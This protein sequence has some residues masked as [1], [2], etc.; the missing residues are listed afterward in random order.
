MA[1]NKTTGEPRTYAAGIPVYCTY[2]EIVPIAQLKPNPM[3]PNKH[4][5]EQIEALGGIIR[6]SGWRNNITVSTR[7]GLI[8]KGHGRLMAAQLEELKEAP[9]EYQ[10]YA[11][12]AEELA[13]LTADNRLAELAEIDNSKLAEVFAHIDT[14]EI[15]FEQSGYSEEE[16]EKLTTALSEAIH[17]DLED[18]DVV[19][20]PP[21]EPVTKYGDIWILGG[22]HRVMCGS[23]TNPED[24][25]KLLNGE[26]PQILLTDPPYC[27]GGSKESDKSTGSIGT[28]RKNGELPMIAND[29]LSTRGYQNLIAAALA[30]IPCVYAYIFTD[31]RMWVYLFDLS[32]NAGF[33]VMGVGWRSQHELCLF[34]TRAKTHFDGHKGYGNVLEISRSGMEI[35]PG[36]V[37]VIVRRYIRM[38]NSRNVKCIRGGEQIGVEEIAGIFETLPEEQEGGG[39]V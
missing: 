8:V 15:D 31:W 32:E 20:E 38:T 3:N 27:S 11:S 6:R 2:D 26:K 17:N 16:Y 23:C 22:R 34:G 9:V 28:M 30:D 29:I 21:A 13:D 35:T 39:T 1:Q 18:P 36:Y 19:I 5:Q 12:E 7:S 4:P 25:A 24:K 10:H 33:G 37:D 14:G